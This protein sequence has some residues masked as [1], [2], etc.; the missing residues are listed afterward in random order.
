MSGQRAYQGVPAGAGEGRAVS[1][2][3]RV[4]LVGI[5]GTGM[6]ALARLLLETGYQVT[7]SDHKETPVLA[8]LRGLG[9]EI[10]LGQRDG[11]RMGDPD[12]VATSSAIRP[13][14]PEVL[15]A[16]QRAIPVLGRAEMLARAMAGKAT[17][18]VAGT[19]GK[20]T[21][22][23]MVV[24]ILEEAGLDPSFAIGGDIMPRG[25]NA[26]AVAGTHFVGEE[27]L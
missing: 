9:A 27:P 16:R 12:M 4:H 1:G 3:R 19:A 8:T 22:T 7:G 25:V 13:G 26:S 2:Q 6:S 23:G 18:A 11:E 24:S 17:V 15:A 10:W 14:N 21:T 5:G 20:T